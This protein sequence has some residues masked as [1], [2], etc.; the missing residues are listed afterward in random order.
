[1]SASGGGSGWAETWLGEG[2]EVQRGWGSGWQWEGMKGKEGRGKGESNTCRAGLLEPQPHSGTSPRA[3]TS[4]YPGAVHWLGMPV[5]ERHLW[6]D[7]SQ[8]S[9]CRQGKGSRPGLPHC[10][11]VACACLSLIPGFNLEEHVHPD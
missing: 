10:L 9:R 2:Q 7:R 5:R 6:G 1:M 3:E 11:V 8:Q 4:L